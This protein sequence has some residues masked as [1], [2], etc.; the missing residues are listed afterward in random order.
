MMTPP[1]LPL[2]TDAVN[3]KQFLLHSDGSPY[4]NH[5]IF[6]N[7]TAFKLSVLTTK[8]FR[9]LHLLDFMEALPVL[10]DVHIKVLGDILLE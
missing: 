4:L 9:A 8:R 10:R 2:F 3:L 5:F 1:L 6:P 7:L